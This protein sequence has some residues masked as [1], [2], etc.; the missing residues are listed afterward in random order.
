MHWQGQGDGRIAEGP[1]SL[2]GSCSKLQPPE[3]GPAPANMDDRPGG[4]SKRHMITWCTRHNTEGMLPMQCKVQ[5]LSSSQICTLP[6]GR[7]PYSSQADL[8]RR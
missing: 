8:V 3:S 4:G 6:A 7:T 1:A 5:E 2:A